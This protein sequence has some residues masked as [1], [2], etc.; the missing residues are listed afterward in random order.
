MKQYV[1]DSTGKFSGRCKSCGSG[2]FEFRSSFA[3]PEEV[4]TVPTNKAMSFGDYYN[5]NAQSSMAIGSV[6]K[7]EPNKN[8]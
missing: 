3:S 7:E 6:K 5:Q 8:Q 1:K 2:E 4:V